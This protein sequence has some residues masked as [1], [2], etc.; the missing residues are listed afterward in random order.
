MADEFLALVG[1]KHPISIGN[2]GEIDTILC[3]PVP[4]TEGPLRGVTGLVL[5]DTGADKDM[6]GSG[7]NV[8]ICFSADNIAW[9]IYDTTDGTLAS[10]VGT[11]Y[12]ND[13][14]FVDLS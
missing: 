8:R 13:P 14:G 2:I 3:R 12:Y 4:N 10:I 11:Q 1:L 7:D 5:L 9:C 6:T